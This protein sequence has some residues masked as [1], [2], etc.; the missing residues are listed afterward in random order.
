[1]NIE[2]DRKALKLIICIVILF[3]GVLMINTKASADSSRFEDTDIISIWRVTTSGY[4]YSPVSVTTLVTIE[5]TNSPSIY[6][7][8]YRQVYSQTMASY[9]AVYPNAQFGPVSLNIRGENVSIPTQGTYLYNPSYRVVGYYNNSSKSYVKNESS[10]GNG[11]TGFFGGAG[12]FQV[13]NT[14][15][16]DFNW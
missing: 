14:A 4:I 10:T 1:M 9:W 8:N 5:Y 11:V 16:V 13:D 3:S 6:Y 15:Q 12:A 2:I 7:V